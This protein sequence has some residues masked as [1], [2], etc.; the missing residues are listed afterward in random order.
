[1]T[2]NTGSREDAPR[3]DVCPAHNNDQDLHKKLSR[4]KPAH[5]IFASIKEA[6]DRFSYFLH[7]RL[8]TQPAFLSASLLD[9]MHSIS[10]FQ[11]LTN[12]LAPSSWSWAARASMSIPALANLA[13]TSSQL[14]PSRGQDRAD[15]PMIGEGFQGGLG[16]RVHGK[17]RGQRLDVQNVGSLGV[18]GAGAGP[19]QTLGAGAGVEDPL[20]ARRSRADARYAS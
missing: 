11:D 10:S 19:Q 5:P 9:A 1:M 20:P 6:S 8:L 3:L 14:P 15:L 2:D 4:Q 7:P 17:R 18:L 12:D 16:H 13:S